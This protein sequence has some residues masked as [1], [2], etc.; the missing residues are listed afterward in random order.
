MTPENISRFINNINI[1][2][3]YGCD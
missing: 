2:L 3:A 1:K